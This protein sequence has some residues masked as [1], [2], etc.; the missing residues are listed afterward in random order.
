MESH[1]I[2][3]CLLF[4]V[5]NCYPFPSSEDNTIDNGEDGSIDLSQYGTKLFGTPDNETGKRV[6]QYNPDIDSDI[7]PEELGGYLEGDMLMPHGL[8]RNGLL[9]S[10]SRWPGGIVPYEI[11][12]GFS[13]YFDI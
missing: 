1:L 9:A 13:E 2:L 10:S 6:A 7:N 8:A 5:A 11:N 4:T 3:V 12:G